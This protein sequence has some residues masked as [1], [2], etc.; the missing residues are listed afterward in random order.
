MFSSRAI[1][2]TKPVTRD[3]TVEVM[4]LIA[5]SFF[6][7]CPICADS[8]FRM[9][10]I[11]SNPHCELAV[12]ENCVKAMFGTFGGETR[13]YDEEPCKWG[14][15]AVLT[16]VTYGRCGVTLEAFNCCC[17][18]CKSPVTTKTAELAVNDLLLKA[19]GKRTAKLMAD[20]PDTD[21]VETVVQKLIAGKKMCLCKN[22]PAEEAEHFLLD[23]DVRA[24]QHRNQAREG[25]DYRITPCR[26]CSIFF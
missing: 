8:V 26:N 14:E 21:Q 16:R 7:E 4:R 5:E 12:C 13:H 9:R 25:E 23:E 6:Q 15:K 2:A 20:A 18:Y 19:L 24:L 22:Y 1:P 10:T 3:S 17:P 11:C